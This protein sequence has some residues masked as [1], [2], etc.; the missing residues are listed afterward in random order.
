M[1]SSVVVLIPCKVIDVLPKCSLEE[2]KFSSCFWNNFE[3]R[4]WF[5]VEGLTFEILLRSFR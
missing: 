5:Y 3:I 1:G 4:F 2:V